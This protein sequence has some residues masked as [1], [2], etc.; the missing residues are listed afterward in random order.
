MFFRPIRDKIKSLRRMI[1]KIGRTRGTAPGDVAELQRL[2][3]SR[4]AEL[5]ARERAASDPSTSSQS[6]RR[7]A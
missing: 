5:E 3:L 2:M 4:I 7:A 6:D 1:G